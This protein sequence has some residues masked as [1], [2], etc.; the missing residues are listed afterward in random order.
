MSFT[1]WLKEA[2][3]GFWREKSTSL[4]SV[5]TLSFSILVLNIFLVLTWNMKKI[6]SQIK[7]RIEMEVYLKD[8]LKPEKQEKIKSTILGMPGV[9]AVFFK[10]KAAALEEMKKIFP[11]NILNDLESNP[12]PSSFVIKLKEKEKSFVHIELLASQIKNISGVEDLEYG[13][14]YLKKLE[15]IV[16]TFFWVDFFFGI[17]IALSILLLV[18]NTIRL[19]ISSR[20]ESIEV[21]K[22]LGASK[23]LISTPFRLEGMIHGFLS[24]VLSLVFLF[25]FSKVFSYHFIKIDFLPL[26]LIIIVAL[27]SILLGWMGSIIAV[28]RFLR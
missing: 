26:E 18:A 3:Y 8:D 4:I 11:P 21:L 16:S 19:I 22:L 5:L 2:F 24:G 28:G 7:E 1:Y 25:I 14:T 9:R 15:T 23:K 12:L 10:S 13:G 20:A 6:E 17:F 27:G